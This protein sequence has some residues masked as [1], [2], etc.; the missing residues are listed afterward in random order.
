VFGDS[1]PVVTAIKGA[2]GEC[3]AA[4][5]AA[6]VAAVA[7]GALGRV[8]PIAGLHGVDPV[9]A[10]LDPAATA[11]DAPGGIALVNAIASGGALFSLV[12][13]IHRQA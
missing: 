10:P 11:K 4:S 8:P 12:L 2:I 1:R 13:R 9:A 7:C 6:C 5:A 3:G